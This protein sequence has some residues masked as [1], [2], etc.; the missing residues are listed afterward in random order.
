MYE[1]FD[2]AQDKLRGEA[3]ESKHAWAKAL[4]CTGFKEALGLSELAE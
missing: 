1:P 3:A 4:Q 2:Y